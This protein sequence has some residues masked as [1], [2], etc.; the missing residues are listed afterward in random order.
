QTVDRRLERVAGLL[1]AVELGVGPSQIAQRL[2]VLGIL[3][4]ARHE[5]LDGLVHLAAVILGVPLVL[6]AHSLRDVL[7]AARAMRVAGNGRPAPRDQTRER[8]DPPRTTDHSIPPRSDHDSGL[9][10]ATRPNVAPRN[11]AA[12]RHA[13]IRDMKISKYSMTCEICVSIV[14]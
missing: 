7:N 5:L 14:N 11:F 8:Q 1:R 4:S 2:E 9:P 3:L 10:F 12:F 6:V 13:S